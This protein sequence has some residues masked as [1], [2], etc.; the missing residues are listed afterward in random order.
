[1]LTEG[2]SEST[3]SVKRRVTATVPLSPRGDA[4]SLVL[5]PVPGLMSI[6][7][8]FMKLDH[9]L[10]MWLCNLLV[11]LSPGELLGIIKQEVGRQGAASPVT[12]REVQ[13]CAECRVPSA[14]L[15]TAL[16]PWEP[17]G[18]PGG[19]GGAAAG[20]LLGGVQWVRQGCLPPGTSLCSSL[21]RGP[22]DTMT[23]QQVTA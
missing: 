10:S 16:W 19:R 14:C 20:V 12:G 17:T 4:V 23:S 22:A 3:R 18:A 21:A 8:C 1:M 6:M 9:V 7:M 15:G 11:S 5:G 13:R 2:S